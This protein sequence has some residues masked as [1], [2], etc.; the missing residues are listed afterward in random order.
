[1]AKTSRDGEDRAIE[2][3]SAVAC[4]AGLRPCR[5]A[6][7]RVLG[8]GRV[9]GNEPYAATADFFS[10]WFRMR[11]VSA[12]Q[13]QWSVTM[14]PLSPRSSGWKCRPSCTSHSR[15]I[16]APSDPRSCS[17]TGTPKTRQSRSRW[18][19]ASGDSSSEVRMTIAVFRLGRSNRPSCF[20]FASD[21]ARPRGRT[22]ASGPQTRSH[23]RSSTLHSHMFGPGRKPASSNPIRAETGSG[24]RNT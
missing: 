22:S 24:K 6:S 15:A 2:A 11:G 19:E 3:G 21:S 20:R 7:A 16:T 8:L 9:A 23:G 4:G 5:G 12:P 1:M 10:D 14:S 17:N 18:R 13:A